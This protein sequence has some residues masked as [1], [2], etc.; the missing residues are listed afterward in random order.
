MLRGAAILGILLMNTQSMSMPSGAY[1]NPTSYGLLDLPNYITWGVI[2]VIADVKLLSVFSMMFGAGMVLQ[3]ER[4]AAR[5]RRA[6]GVHYR[7]MF[8]LLLIG[9]IHAYAIWYGDILVAYATCGMLLYPFRRLP[10]PILLVS[11]V[12]CIGAVTMIRY[13]ETQHL[14]PTID[15]L[16]AWQ[17]EIY[18]HGDILQNSFELKVYRSGWWD[19]MQNRAPL[20]FGNQ[21]TWMLLWGFWRYGG[22]MLI[23]MG[24]QKMRF[25]H[26]DWPRD[27]YRAMALLLIPIGWLIVVAGLLFNISWDWND[28]MYYAYGEMF[29]YWGSL[30][31]AIGYLALGVWIAQKIAVDRTL[32]LRIIAAPVRAIGKTALS[33]YIMQGLICTTLFYGH[34]LGW[35]GYLTRVQLVEVVLCV[36]AWQMIISMIWLRFFSQGPL[37]W[38]WHRLAHGRPRKKLDASPP[39]AP[40]PA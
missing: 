11:G 39:P 25:F 15:Q 17:D 4:L 8:I 27:V 36:W 2:H 30:V 12:L 19:Q 5:N 37:E 7:R 38:I 13:A 40:V 10:V 35:F 6:M 21:T 16:V 32:L 1:F 23:G 31:T 14:S 18:H 3:A 28:N 29:N 26:G 34:G 24:L 9:L 33:N 20:S 22:C